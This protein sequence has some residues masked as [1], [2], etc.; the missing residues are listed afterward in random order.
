MESLK[1]ILQLLSNSDIEFVVIGGLAAVIY[2]SS[3]VTRDLDV[4]VAMN[5]DNIVRLRKVLAPYHL[6]KSKKIVG[7]PKDHATVLELNVIREKMS[8]K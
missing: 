1:N 3:Q 2:G 4:C 8:L 7:R 6:I 5:P